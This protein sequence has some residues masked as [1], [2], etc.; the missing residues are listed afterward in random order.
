MTDTKRL[1]IRESVLDVITLLEDEPVEGG[2][3]IHLTAVRTFN[4]I[5]LEV[6]PKSHWP[7]FA[8]Q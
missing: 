3:F 5:S 4:R 1:V 2:L 6:W 8:L 7:G